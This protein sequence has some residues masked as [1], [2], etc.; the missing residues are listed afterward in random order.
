MPVL[1]ATGFKI[2]LK[3]GWIDDVSPQLFYVFPLWFAYSDQL[4]RSGIDIPT[5]RVVLFEL[6]LYTIFAYFYIAN[7]ILGSIVR[8]RN[9]FTGFKALS[10]SII[11]LSMCVWF[12]VLGFD[13]R[14]SYKAISVLHSMSGNMWSLGML[15][16][17]FSFVS[18][19]VF[20]Q[21]MAALHDRGVVTR[22]GHVDGQ[23]R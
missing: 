12:L 17:G 18:V 7:G 8:L 21:V 10:L 16:A 20:W 11:M 9:S 4:D 5:I 1:G 19:I 22:G 3:N 15:I 23:A 6:S 13:D 2:I 14:K